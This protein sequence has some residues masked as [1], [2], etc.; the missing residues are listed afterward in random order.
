MPLEIRGDIVLRVVAQ[1]T[2]DVS[3]SGEAFTLDQGGIRILDDDNVRHEF[4]Y[5]YD[6]DSRFDLVVT[7]TVTDGVVEL[8]PPLI[9]V[10]E[11][12]D[13]EER[14]NTL[15]ATFRHDPETDDEPLTPVSSN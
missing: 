1:E 6:R 9:E 4:V 12:K 3:V 5:R 11:S 7:A 2:E 15:E 10:K 8:D 13:I 14:R